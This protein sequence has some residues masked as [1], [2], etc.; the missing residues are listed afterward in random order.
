[1]PLDRRTPGEPLTEELV[2]EHIVPE[3]SL[4]MQRKLDEMP[5]LVIHYQFTF[6]GKFRVREGDLTLCIRTYIDETK[7]KQLQERISIYIANTLE[8]GTY[9]TKP[10]ETFFLSRYVLDEDCFQT[11]IPLGSLPF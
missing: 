6:N 3:L 8:V 10:L 2:R 7:K 1:M 9:P 5:S 11:R 4:Y